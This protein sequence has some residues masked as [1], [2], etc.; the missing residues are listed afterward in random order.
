MRNISCLHPARPAARRPLAAACLVFYLLAWIGMPLPVAPPRPAGATAERYPCEHHHCG[1]N[2]A[3]QCWTNCCCLSPKQRLAWAKTN[4][5]KPPAWVMRSL[6]TE[7][8][9]EGMVATSKVDACCAHKHEDATPDNCGTCC[10]RKDSQAAPS[11]EG[12]APSSGVAGRDTGW[13]SLLQA[14]RCRGVSTEWLASGAVLI[15]S[16]FCQVEP[17]RSSTFISPLTIPRFEAPLQKPAVPPPRSC[18][19]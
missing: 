10:S 3:E 16:V 15:S 11:S 8:A 4:G 12:Y 17:D 5:T 2:T 19:A 1:C 9:E 14:Q 18:V 7:A 13:I 6:E